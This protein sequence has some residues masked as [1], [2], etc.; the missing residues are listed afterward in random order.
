MELL[1][2]AGAS[3]DDPKVADLSIHEENRCQFYFRGK[4]VSEENPAEENPEKTRC[5]FSFLPLKIE[6]TPISSRDFFADFFDFFGHRFLCIGQDLSPNPSSIVKL[7]KISASG[8]G[9][10]RSWLDCS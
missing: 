1:A 6:L 4:S 9:L 5:Q 3:R 2:R 8:N 7:G 10:D